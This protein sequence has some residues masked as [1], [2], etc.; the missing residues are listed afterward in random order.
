M[1]MTTETP[2]KSGIENR[3]PKFIN[4][5][6]LYLARRADGGGPR[7]V[8]ELDAED[9]R[10][11][12]IALSA[13][14]PEGKKLADLQGDGDLDD[15]TIDR[16]HVLGD[17]VRE[18]LIRATGHGHNH[19]WHC[20]LGWV[21]D[22]VTVAELALTAYGREVAEERPD[23]MDALEATEVDAPDTEMDE[24]PPG[25]TIG[26]DGVTAPHCGIIVDT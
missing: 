15:E 10:M 7:F 19:V 1:A 18:L 12:L 17:S 5:G 26:K 13:V 25:V 14:L 9:L 2:A 24:E 20:L 16:M 3:D 6:E 23:E 8:M 22:D 4:I 21:D 11:L